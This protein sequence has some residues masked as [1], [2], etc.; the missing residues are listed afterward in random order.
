[1]EYWPAAWWWCGSGGNPSGYGGG[2]VARRDLLA[3]PWGRRR[4]HRG[5]LWILWTAIIAGR[6]FGNGNR[7]GTG[8]PGNT[9]AQQAAQAWP[10]QAGQN[11]TGNLT[12]FALGGAAVRAIGGGSGNTVT[13]ITGPAFFP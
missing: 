6:G 2:A 10:G 11:G 5:L 1:M 4:N 9:V 3:A 12:G 13:N 8:A 7:G